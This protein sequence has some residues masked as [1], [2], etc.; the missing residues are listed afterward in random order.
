MKLQT[1]ILLIVLML[2]CAMAQAKDIKR[3]TSYNYTRGVE[4][5]EQ[6]NYAEAIEYLKKEL[7]DNPKNGY[8]QLRLGIIAYEMDEYGEGLTYANDALKNLNKKDKEYLGYAH[9]LRASLNAELGNHDQALSDFAQALNYSPDNANIY[10]SRAKFYGKNDQYDLATAD[11]L[12]Y[13]RLNP[14][15]VQGYMGLGYLAMEQKQWDDARKHFDYVTKLEP[16]YADG[17]TQR[18]R[19]NLALKK[20][21]EA[22]DDIIT[23]LTKQV[24]NEAIH[25]MME[26]ADSAL[27]PIAVKTRVQAAKEPNNSMWSYCL[28]GIYETVEQ[29]HKAIKY[30]EESLGKDTD[31]QLIHSRLSSCYSQLGDY[32]NALRHI[33]LLIESDT[34]NM[35][36]LYTR[37]NIYEQLGM[38][39][40]ARIDAN[41][42]IEHDPDHVSG[43]L[44]RGGL[45][46]L[47]KNYDKAL[48]DFTT[49]T[50]LD[51]DN[52]RAQYQMGRLLWQLGRRDEARPYLER[53]L[54]L[55]TVAD[56]PYHHN[57]Y[58]YQLLGEPEKAR[59][60]IA[61]LMN[62][63]PVTKDN[64]YDY[65]CAYALL[66]DTEQAIEWMRKAMSMGFRQFEHVN[67]D[68]DMDNIRDLQAFKNL[69]S[70]YRAIFA[71][72]LA[73]HS[74]N[75]DDYEIRIVEIP[76]T[77]E[78]KLCK[79]K[80][81]INGLPLHF[82]FDTGASDV[83]MSTV[84]AT[85]MFKNDYLS[86][87]DVTGKA[88][89]VTANGEISEGTIV[90]LREVNFGGLSLTNVK[91][92][93]VRSQ[94]APL[95]LGQSV[96][97]KLG[98]IEIDNARHVLKIT[99]RIPKE[100]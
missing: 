17:Y 46:F 42:I 87:R 5:Y 33:N 27:T 83:S 50:T 22:S 25:V 8:A 62:N 48:D 14:G 72:E 24:S 54:E 97:G 10:L 55:D 82:I 41:T 37:T 58:V 34:T 88:N 28:G 74:V 65:A 29:Y 95:L 96:L 43:Y 20:Y 13:N 52:I 93:I 30:Y 6:N 66:G 94:A 86:D 44:N 77:S 98:K 15:Q 11:F 76:F 81:T 59:E 12:Q 67:R 26:I 40:S 92:S 23:S 39:D 56:A 9:L 79:V 16:G 49:A 69:M 31:N 64:A 3:P 78:G 100:N 36:A 4:L 61:T 35:S 51:Q 63:R 91:A 32:Q 68:P 70:E 53:V 71:E 18:A 7:S 2:S 60:A 84:E 80:C 47:S 1:T 19:A 89:Y 99:H 21:N 57:Q 73:D 75:G 90:N 85:F 38:V 45:E